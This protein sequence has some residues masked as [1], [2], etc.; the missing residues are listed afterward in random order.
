MFDDPSPEGIAR[1]R[2]RALNVIGLIESSLTAAGTSFDEPARWLDFG[3]G[4]GR[5]LRFLC[6]RVPPERVWACDVERRGVDF[7]RSEF[8]VHGTYSSTD[9]EHLS[10]GT[11]DFVFAISVLSHLD[12]RN[13]RAFVRVLGGALQPGGILLFTTHGRWSLEHPETYGEEYVR[14]GRE[15]ADAVKA[16]GACFLRYPYAEG[17]DYGMAWHSKQHVESLV[18]ERFGDAFELLMFEPHGL[19]GHQDVYAFRRRE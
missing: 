10:L 14:R 8:G 3:C 4:Y 17:D 11:F 13:S 19:D 16:S 5:V 18:R 12:E 9:L 2:A 7:C 1:Y 6:E 15:I